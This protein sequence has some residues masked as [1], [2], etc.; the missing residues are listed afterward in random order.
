MRARRR[1]G[2]IGL[3]LALALSCG[4]GAASASADWQ[5]PPGTLKVEVLDSAGHP[6]DRAGAHP[7]RIVSSVRTLERPDGTL[8]GASTQVIS[9]QGGIGGDPN[10]VPTCPRKRFESALELGCPAESQV[11]VQTAVHRGGETEATPIYNLE[12]AAGEVSAFGTVQFFF[13]AKFV[14][15]L[16]ASDFGL[17]TRLEG[18]PEVSFGEPIVETQIEFWGVP[19][20]H[21]EGTSL[22]RRAFLTTPTRC[23]GA[24]GIDVRLRT[25]ARPTEWGA[26]SA[27]TGRAL[28]GCQS[29]SYAPAV[30]MEL[31]TPVADTPTGVSLETIFPSNVDASQLASSQTRSTSIELP[32]GM[33]FSAGAAEGLGVCTDA[34]LARGSETAASCPRDAKV[35]TVELGLAALKEPLVGNLYIGEEHPGERF[36]IF[37]VA[38][39]GGT[40]SKFVSAMRPDPV[41]GRLTA[42]LDDLP[43]ISFDYL[44]MRFDGGPAGLLVAPRSC[45]PA[46]ARGTFVPYSGGP[47][48]NSNST[49]AI[50]PRA[51]R[52]CGEPAPFEPT[53]QAAISAR[54]GGRPTSFTTVLSRRDGEQLTDRFTF[55]LPQGISASLAKV[56]RCGNAAAA[57][58][59]CPAAS[60]VGNAFVEIGSGPET[61]EMTGSAYLTGP[62]RKGPFGFA[63]I[64]NATIGPFHLG[65]FIVRAAMKLD[66]ETGQVSVQ[67]DSMPQTFEGVP[68]RFQ[69]IG[70]EI[71]RPGFMRTPTSCAPMR[72]SSLIRSTEGAVARP[73][74]ELSVRD[75]VSLPF[76][77]AVALAL[78][79]RSQLHKGGR[80]GLRIGTRSRSGDANLRSMQLELPAGLRFRS[81]GLRAICARG[82]ALKGDCPKGAQV[83]TGFGRTPMLAKPLRG[84][85]YVVQPKGNGEPDL[86]AHLE[87]EGVELNLPSVNSTEHGRVQTSF[88]DVP[89]MALS[90]FTLDLAGGKHGLLVLDRDLCGKVRGLNAAASLE[91]QNAATRELR[92]PVDKP[93]SCKGE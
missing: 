74:V 48:V 92:V 7:D 63:L 69:R 67:S 66:S 68:V 30:K 15:H 60:K 3:V 25:Y 54:R 84:A 83:G 45:G 42:V 40:E 43:Q 62:Y 81:G 5:I 73:G 14:G 16:R 29:L 32:E 19:A 55:T 17:E 44:L 33:A 82:A 59:A 8:E 91:G 26:G 12:P 4:G 46:T 50:G 36:R 87:G 53:L 24:V 75:C 34:Q 9:F 1:C 52:R 80:P 85:I 56:E 61:A 88:E 49:V 23:D 27:D 22:P 78:S 41:T 39:G 31:E 21:Q 37:V 18:I 70:L 76:K 58:G 51:G 93:K 77:P 72:V 65:S 71:N 28:S 6:D 47:R 90:S 64:L 38:R 79:G 57:A 13:R 10:S 86:W 20:D 89:D 2:W 35:G 11:G